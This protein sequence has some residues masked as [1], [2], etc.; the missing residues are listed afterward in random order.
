MHGQQQHVGVHAHAVRHVA[1]DGGVERRVVQ[2]EASVDFFDGEV[3][4]EAEH[5]AFHRTPDK[6]FVVRVP[7][8]VGQ[9]S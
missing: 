8:G 2:L 5:V 6:V 3:A 7:V 9:Q 4:V 1:I